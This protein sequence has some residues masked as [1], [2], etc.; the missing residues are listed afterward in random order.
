MHAVIQRATPSDLTILAPLF[1]QYRQFYEYPPDLSLAT[2]FLAER[3]ERGESAIFLARNTPAGTA[4]G[5]TQLYASFCSTAAVPLLILY[6]LFVVPEA[7]GR[8][9]GRGLME[10]AHAF[11]RAQGFKRVMLQTAHSNTTAQA[12]YESMGYRLDA[13]F[14]VYELPL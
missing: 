7:R 1:D 2:R 3:L 9:V 6:D 8:G 10:R 12:L 5:F 11:G 14:R 4:L 13:G